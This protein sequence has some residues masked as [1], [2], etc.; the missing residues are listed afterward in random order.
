MQTDSLSAHRVRLPFQQEFKDA[1]DGMYIPSVLAVGHQTLRQFDR[2]SA[3]IAAG[4]LARLSAAVAVV[5]SACA[6][7]RRCQ[8]SHP[9]HTRVLQ[10]IGVLSPKIDGALDDKAWEGAALGDRFWIVE[11]ERW[12]TEQTEVM[13]TADAKFLHIAF[14]VYD[15]QPDKIVALETRRD[16]SLGLDDL[17][18]VELDPFLSHREVSDYCINA[19]EPSA[20]QSPGPRQPAGMERHLGREQPNVH[21]R[22]VG[23]DVHSFRDPQL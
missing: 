11:Q 16:A 13:V 6:A 20:I 5:F 12:P 2:T 23:G 18:Y 7:L 21:L 4:W 3:I 19:R 17:V 15:S 9:G 1:P 10:S 22:L 14:R 8:A